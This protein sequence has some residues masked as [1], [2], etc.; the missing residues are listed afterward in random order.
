MGRKPKKES[1][2]PRKEGFEPLS[3]E[4]KTPATVVLLLNSQEEDIL[5]KA[6]EAIHTFAEKGDENRVSLLGLGALEPLCRLIAHSNRLVRRNAFIALGIMATNGDVNNVLKKADAIPSMIQNLTPEEDVIVLEF[7]TLCLASLSV[8]FTCRVQIYT[9]NGMPPIIKLLTSSDPDVTKNSLEIIF[10]LVQD[11]KCLQAVH[12]LGG[13]ASLL[14]LLKSDFPVIQRL[15]LKTLQCV[16]SDKETRET[17]REE[18]GFEKL[19]DI[20]SNMDLAD[21]HGE[22]LHTVANC[23]MDGETL[24]LIHNNGGLARL[25][26]FVLAPSTPA[27]QSTAVQCLSRV[28]QSCESRSVLHEQEVEK[29]LVELL[30]VADDNVKASACQAVAA[31]SFHPASKDSFRDWGGLPAVAQL[32]NGESSA[33]REAATQALSSLTHGNQP[34]ALAVYEAGCHAVLIQQLCGSSARTVANSAA[35]LCNMAEQEIIQ[36]SVLSHGGIQALVE[37]L[38]SNDT[39][40]LINA[41]LCVAVLACDN[42]ARAKFQKAGGLEPLVALLRSNDKEVLQ[43]ACFAVDVCAGETSCAVE[44]CR[45]GALEILQQINQSGNRRTSFSELAMISLLN[46]NLPVK[47]SLMGHLASTDIITS[48]FYDAGKVCLGQTVLTLEELSKQPVNQNRA[49]I[50]VDIA[51]EYEKH[52]PFTTSKKKEKEKQY[53]E[54]QESP[55]EKQNMMEDVYLQMLIREAKESV[56]PLKDEQEQYA[57]LARLVSKAMGGAVATEKLHQFQWVLHHSELKF[58]LKSNV[59]PIGLINK[60]I[61]CHRALLF[62]CLADC[63]EKGCTL[64]R[65]EYNRAWNEVVL[66]GEDP[67]N[68]RSSQPRRYIVDLM[69]QP[70]TL[71]PVDTPAAAMY[72]T[73]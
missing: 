13:I 55:P 61:Y 14:E 17:F 58:Q 21:L 50:V 46:T 6:C 48:G 35:T 19:M 49:I 23:L 11:Y 51:T 3:L 1:E 52:F 42:E 56:L 63:I 62:K 31:M 18:Q 69:H 64:V 65:G 67:D 12:E 73:I 10:N 16:T 44:M 57:A 22:A 8:D 34:N 25:M 4:S 30:S 26:D 41:T 28:A 54:A 33:L 70:G 36:S 60:G 24:Q 32:L 27:I 15:A 37:P 66:F 59:I 45:L 7:A 47:Y 40:V 2:T 68:Q 5:V 72:Q 38:R 43:K 29:A 71:L 53:E 39:Q 20:L 9:N